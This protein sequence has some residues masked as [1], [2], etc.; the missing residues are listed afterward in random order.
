MGLP[1]T[2]VFTH[3]SIA[4]G[5]DGPTH[6]PVEQLA[7]LRAMPNLSVIRP[8][9]GNETAAAWKLAV[10]STDKPTALVLTRQNLPT[11]DQ[12]PEKAYEG[13]EKGGYVVVEAADAQPEALLLASGSEVGLAIEAQKALEKEGI[14]AS[15]VSLPAWD[16]FDQQSDE[17]KESVLPT[18]VRARIAIEMGASLGWERYTGLDGDVIAIDKFGASAPGE[19]IIEKYGFT[20]SNVVSRVKAKLNK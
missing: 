8:A 7:S 5:E 19:T 16:R 15:V 12:A 2:Y 10:S 14:R 4:V 6:E 17:Y 11:I 3:D 18:A 1:V 13:V 9:D 20:V